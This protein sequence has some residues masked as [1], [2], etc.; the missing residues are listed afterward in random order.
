[1]SSNSREC[2]DHYFH[3][4]GVLESVWV[5]PTLTL[6]PLHPQY[7]RMR[8]TPPHEAEVVQHLQLIPRKAKKYPRNGQTEQGVQRGQG[9]QARIPKRRPKQEMSD[10]PLDTINPYAMGRK[11]RYAYIFPTAVISGTAWS[12]QLV[13]VGGL[14]CDERGC[15]MYPQKSSTLLQQAEVQVSF[16]SNPVAGLCF[17]LLCAFG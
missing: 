12:T 15:Q 4:Y 14:V 7:D 1:M 11:S 9:V 6:Y 10:A 13:G 17:N 8:R 2:A 5:N 16:S 3:L